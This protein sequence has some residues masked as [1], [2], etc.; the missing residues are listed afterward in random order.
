MFDLGCMSRCLKWKKLFISSLTFFCL[1]FLLWQ[2]GHRAW[3]G[4]STGTEQ[5]HTS[6]SPTIFSSCTQER[7][8]SHTQLLLNL[9]SDFAELVLLITSNLAFICSALH[10]FPLQ[11]QP[12]AYSLSLFLDNLVKVM[13]VQIWEERSQGGQGRRSWGWRIT[14]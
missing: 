2:Q 6:G 4:M 12:C 8:G 3:A 14:R 9:G 10:T 13:W 7:C 1:I 11:H 5:Q